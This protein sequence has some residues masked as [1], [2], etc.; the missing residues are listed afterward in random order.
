MP[1]PYKAS[2]AYRRFFRVKILGFEFSAEHTVV[3]IRVD[4]DLEFS[5]FGI[6]TKFKDNDLRSGLSFHYSGT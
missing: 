2:H 4:V 5:L 1:K 6:N 3:I